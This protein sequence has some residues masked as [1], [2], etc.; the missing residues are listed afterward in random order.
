MQGRIEGLSRRATYGALTLL[1]VLF[2]TGVY[3][4]GYEDLRNREGLMNPE[5]GNTVIS[6]PVIISANPIGSVVAHSSM[7]LAAVTHAY[8]SKDRLPPQ[9]FVDE[10]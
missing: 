7:H 8:E 10:D 3:H 9:T 1:L 5:I 4:A 6:I 2:I